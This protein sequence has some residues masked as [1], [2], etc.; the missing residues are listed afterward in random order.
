MRYNIVNVDIKPESG[1]SYPIITGSELIQNAGRYI[2]NYLKAKKILVVTNNTIY[3]LYGETLKSSLEEAEILHDFVILNDGEIYKNI[4]S[5]QSLWSKALEI[6]L[7]RK[8][9]FLAL[10][11]GVIGDMTGF[12]A[13]TYLRGVDFIQIPTTLLAQVD[14]SVGGK[15]GINLKEGKNL[16]GAFY[17]P[18]IVIADINTLSS[19]SV[20]ELKV[21]LAEVV[22]YAFIEKSCGLNETEL[23][24]FSFLKAN[25]DNIF[26]LKPD[27]MIDLISY[28]C[29]LKAAVVSQDEKES[30]IRAILNFGHTIVHAIEKCSDYKNITH[31]KAVAIG[32]KGA[33]YIAFERGLIEQEYLDN[34]LNIM[35][36]YDMDYKIAE[37][38][39]KQDLLSAMTLD[40]KVQSGKI[41]FIMPVAPAEAG[42]FSD[43]DSE[44]ILEALEKLY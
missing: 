2:V 4:D 3:Q 39:S 35:K 11:G 24:L 36:L 23:D 6:K 8:D 31:G 21:G 43:I 10:G 32:I 41:R 27:V 30:G 7:E 38:I 9:G 37:N 44:N 18:K 34:A 16:E 22:K 28:C 42:I 5:I 20:N 13:A 25:R 15:V 29:K 12:A 33:F 26:S 14:S 17:Q 19:L 40:K 1:R